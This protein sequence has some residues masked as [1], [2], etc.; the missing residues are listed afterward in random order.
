MNLKYLEEKGCYI[1]EECLRYRI[2]ITDAGLLE[3]RE[4]AVNG[5][6]NS[7]DIINK[8][9]QANLKVYFQFSQ[10]WNLSDFKFLFGCSTVC[11]QEYLP[12]HF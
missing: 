4:E 10:P 2:L 1:Y 5:K 6:Q 8:T 11:S 3:S 12:G 7:E 9:R